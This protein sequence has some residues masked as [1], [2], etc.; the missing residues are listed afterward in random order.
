MIPEPASIENPSMV[1]VSCFEV[2]CGQV[3]ALT[4]P[5]GY[6]HTKS[7][8]PVERSDLNVPPTERVT[9]T[10][11]SELIRE[12]DRL[13]KNR[14]KFVL[15]AVKRELIRRRREELKRS[16][17]NPHPETEA[18]AELGFDDWARS[19]P[20]EN[21]SELLDPNAGR[22]VRWIPGEG[23]IDETE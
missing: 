23:W 19:L 9:V 20:Q 6:D 18:F 1:V 11:P 21:L 8:R 4:W 13:E 7:M 3:L 2:E 17:E 10:L 12:I 22:R 14:S 16:L 15:A 5:S